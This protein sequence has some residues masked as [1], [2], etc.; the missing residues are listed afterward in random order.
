MGR[1]RLP[2]RLH[3][4]QI[5]PE[6]RCRYAKSQKGWSRAEKRAELSDRSTWLRFLLVLQSVGEGG[7]GEG[8]TVT[9]LLLPDSLPEIKT[10]TKTK[11]KTSSSAF[12]IQ[13]KS[14]TQTTPAKVLAGFIAFTV[15]C[16][17]EVYDRPC[18][19]V[20]VTYW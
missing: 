14:A 11:T 9:P 5:P 7:G 15:T 17:P 2:L 10:K 6:K 20:P 13:K 12:R 19:N 18:D 16:E 1:G 8:G 3:S 4:L